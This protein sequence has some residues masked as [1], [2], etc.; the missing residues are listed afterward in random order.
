M[1]ARVKRQRRDRAIGPYSAT[2]R[3][4]VI[5]SPRTGHVPHRYRCITSCAVKQFLLALLLLLATPAP[6]RAV[7]VVANDLTD[8]YEVS[9]AVL[10][11]Q[12]FP[13][14]SAASSC[15][16]CHWRIIRIC[17]DG[18]LEGRT[19]CVGTTCS[20]S[21]DV[22]EVW[23]AQAPVLPPIGDPLWTYR[24]TVCLSEPPL[25]VAPL[26]AE[27]RDMAVRDLPALRAA[28][29]PTGT[30]LTGLPTYFRAGQPA[31]FSPEPAAIAGALVT[32]HA[33]PT[34]TWDFGQGAPLTTIDPGGTYPAGGV[35]HVY[36]RRGVY[37][38]RV[39]CDWRATYS[40]RGLTDLPVDGVITQS[41]WF[42]LRVKEA[43]RYLTTKGV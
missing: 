39:T 43:R 17:S 20:A 22:A 27:L 30:T 14:A 33:Q 4:V 35:R 37:R 23:R 41:A 42:D 24:G 9:G 26:V 40:T 1:K 15:S 8:A 18:V 16:N 34:W 10:L 31:S 19:G 28:S 11:N 3:R 2:G 38:V 36:P 7:D 6:A 21:S 12:T 29:S 32:L 5:H 25:A 13:E